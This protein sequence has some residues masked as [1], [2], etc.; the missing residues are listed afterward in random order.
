MGNMCESCVSQKPKDQVQV[1]KYW[2]LYAAHK[3][4]LAGISLTDRRKSGRHRRNKTN[5]G[6]NSPEIRF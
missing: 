5:F 4:D 1:P 2:A 6:S 3:E